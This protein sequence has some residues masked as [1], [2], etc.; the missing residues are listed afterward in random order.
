MEIE[1][2]ISDLGDLQEQIRLA[3]RKIANLSGLVEISKIINSTLEIDMLLTI[4]MEIIK[5]VLNAESG[6]LM[7]I[8]EESQELVYRVTLGKKG[9][10]LKEK[11]RL[12]MGQGIAGWVAK[13]GKPLLV[14][15]VRK[16]SRFYP[17]P[18]KKLRHRT[19]SI[20][21]V[22]LESQG[23]TLGVLEAINS[24]NPG[25]FSADDMDMFFAFAS[26]AAV[27]IERA[28]LHSR[29]L[30][31]QRVVQELMIAHQI[32]KDFLPSV[33]PKLPGARFFAQTLPA[34]ET[35][36]DFFDF[37]KMGNGR[38]GAVIGDVSGKGVPAALYMVRALS[39]FRFHASSASSVDSLLN[40]LNKSLISHGTSG[41]FITLIYIML[42]T[43]E[44]TL[45]YGIAGHHPILLRRAGSSTMKLL[46]GNSGVPLGISRKALHV[47]RTVHLEK[48]DL[49]FLYTDGVVEARNREGREFG[50][51]RLKRLLVAGGAGAESTVKRVMSQVAKFSRG[52]PQHDDLTAMAIK[53]I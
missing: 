47:M 24:K 46:R 42:D 38:I 31:R 29:L 41:M 1:D 21:C 23:K 12:R 7:L 8:D 32:Q 25:G 19:R 51:R 37:V 9:K 18:D 50:T 4:I 43:L 2:K 35:G 22:P 36:G 17:G 6:S 33:F 34:W 5:Q 26:Q 27:A 30:E 40:A 28:R 15:D 39:E 48:G 49:L 3:N 13:H 11:F 16:D 10:E 44:R 52:A 53:I 14:P 45:S 20:L